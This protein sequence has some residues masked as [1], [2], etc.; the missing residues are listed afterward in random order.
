MS[1][2]ISHIHKELEKHVDERYRNGAS[3]YFK[4]EVNYIGVR[5]PAVRKIAKKHFK[6]VK[7]LGKEEV[8]KLAEELLERGTMEE[9]IIAFSWVYGMKTD[10]QAKDLI[11]FKRWI[12]EYVHNWAHT[13][14][15]CTNAVGYL[16]YTYPTLLEE[17][18]MWSQS[19]NLWLRRASAVSLIYS[20]KQKKH[21]Q[22]VFQIARD[23]IDDK[24]DLVQKGYGWSLKVA[25][26]I[27]PR[28]VFDFVMKNKESMSRTA[29]RYAIEKMPEDLR[30]QA[31]ER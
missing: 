22:V 23:L 7:K 25:A 11:I 18:K 5:T 20:L 14:D 27:Y 1:G 15:F 31:M 13:D 21:L 10:F 30:H 19:K 6:Q 2:T 9:G 4:E 17:I 8:F 16:V 29:L 26:D 24:E 28:E 3:A 12:L